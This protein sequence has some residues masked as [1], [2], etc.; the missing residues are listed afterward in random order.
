MLANQNALLALTAM[1]NFQS[2]LCTQTL[3]NLKKNHAFQVWFKLA[4][5]IQIRFSDNL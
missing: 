1:L 4:K 2:A 5:S 3:Y